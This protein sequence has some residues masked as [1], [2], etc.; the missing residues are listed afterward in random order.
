MHNYA[1]IDLDP[2][3]CRACC[4]SAEQ[5]DPRPGCSASYLQVQQY[6]SYSLLSYNSGL[7][8][9]SSSAAR[10]GWLLTVT[11]ASERRNVRRGLKGG[12]GEV[13]WGQPLPPPS[14]HTATPT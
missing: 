2:G 9:I 14:S 11:A 8:F 13:R 12:V 3:F 4:F 1:L 6:C 10:A 5:T 7:K